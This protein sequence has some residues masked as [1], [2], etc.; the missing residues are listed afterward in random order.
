MVVTAY[1]RAR[2]RRGRETRVWLVAN[3]LA[4]GLD[5]LR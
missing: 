4:A 1:L 3:G 5:W 2:T